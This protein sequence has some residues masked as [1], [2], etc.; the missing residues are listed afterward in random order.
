[1]ESKMSGK[2]DGD[3]FEAAYR[4]IQEEALRL[5]DR[6]SGTKAIIMFI[7]DELDWSPDFEHRRTNFYRPSKRTGR[8]IHEELLS[9]GVVQTR[10]TRGLVGYRKDIAAFLRTR[11]GLGPVG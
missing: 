7:G 8:S 4:R 11:G 5:A 2:G 3:G 10:V 9:A 1:M 6:L